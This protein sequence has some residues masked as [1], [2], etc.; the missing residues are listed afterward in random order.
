MRSLPIVVLILTLATA[1]QVVAENQLHL[2]AQACVDDLYNNTPVRTMPLGTP[3]RA[4][5]A[6][7]TVPL[8]EACTQSC[9]ERFGPAVSVAQGG[10]PCSAESQKM[11]RLKAETESIPGD[12]SHRAAKK[13]A[14]RAY[15]A[16]VK[17]SLECS[18]AEQKYAPTD[19]F[20]TAW[21]A[22]QD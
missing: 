3:E 15:E 11:W 19:P 13:S 4:A 16:Q 17:R 22:H 5:A 18:R 8:V 12:R 9:R 6:A 10:S 2:C 1:E 14:N 20:W 21:R 7:K